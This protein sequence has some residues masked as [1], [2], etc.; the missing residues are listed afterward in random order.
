MLTKS[1]LKKLAAVCLSYSKSAYTSNGSVDIRRLCEAFDADLVFRPLLV[2]G[3]IGQRSDGGKTWTVLIDSETYDAGNLDSGEGR[4]LFRLN[5]TIAHELVHTLG[6][7]LSDF[8][9]SVSGKDASQLSKDDIEEIEADTEQLSPLLLIP[10]DA[11][12]GFENDC[13]IQRLADVRRR[14]KVSLGVFINRIKLFDRTGEFN[15]FRKSAIG[16]VRKGRFVDEP[17]YS[18]FE[19]GSVPDFL[20]ERASMAVENVFRDYSNSEED[21]VTECTLPAGTFHSRGVDAMPV[22]FSVEGTSGGDA[23]FMIQQ[24]EALERYVD[25]NRKFT[26]EN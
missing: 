11:F 10:T 18:D 8:Q 22:R 26:L 1:Q 4:N 23:I 17:F 6:F 9:I 14:L 24:T 19:D 16:I 25:T 7:R 15:P 20:H 21:F 12:E 2:E 5:N 13:T 3:K